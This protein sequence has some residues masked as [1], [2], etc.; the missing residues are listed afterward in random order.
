MNDRVT[1]T[2]VD[3]PDTQVDDDAPKAEATQV[4]PDARDA[5]LRKPPNRKHRRGRRVLLSA[6]G[7]VVGL[8]VS[9]EIFRLRDAGAF[10]HLNVYEPD[11][12]LG[13]RLRPFA[14]EKV[15][16]NGNPVTDVR[17]GA[18][19][20]RGP[21]LPPR[22]DDEII[23]VGDSQ[24]FGLG[25]Q[26]DETFSAVLSK[27]ANGRVVINAGVP[28]YGPDEY[29]AVAKRL[30]ESRHPDKSTARGLTVVYVVNLANDLFEA[31]RRN[32]DRHEVW[33]GWAV[34]KE[35]APQS[36]TRFPGRTFL[37]RDSHLF[38]ALRGVGVSRST[39]S[40]FGSE[41]SWKDLAVVARDVS[42]GESTAEA[43]FVAEQ[44]KEEEGLQASQLEVEKALLAKHPDLVADKAGKAYAKAHGSPEDIVVEETYFVPSEASRGHE[45]TVH[46][47]VAGAEVRR[48]VEAR[49]RREV[50]AESKAGAPDTSLAASFQERLQKQRKLD[51]LLAAP[52]HNARASSPMAPHL[53]KMKEL[54]D[55]HGARLV[56]VALPLDVQVSPAEWAKYGVSA[57][58]I[59]V[60]STGILADD[61][62][63]LSRDLGVS[64]LDP[65]SALAQAEPGA[66]LRGDLHMTAKGH[67]AL[68]NALL[69]TLREPPPTQEEPLALPAGRTRAPTEE[70]WQKGLHVA[71]RSPPLFDKTYYQP[72]LDCA[73]HTV[74]EW[75]RFVCKKDPAV[76]DPYH[77]G[78][79]GPRP[80]SLSAVRA[81]R[82]TMTLTTDTY[83]S[84]TVPMDGPPAIL[85]IA[86]ETGNG[87]ITIQ[88]SGDAI[89]LGWARKDRLAVWDF[90]QPAASAQAKKAEVTVTP[91]ATDMCACHEAVTKSAA[92]EAF[93]GAPDADCVRTYGSDCKKLL[94][95]EAGD[96]FMAP[97]CLPGWRHAGALE[98]CFQTCGAA[99]PCK[100]GACTQTQGVSLCL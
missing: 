37:Y 35:T 85:A 79:P 24:V 12:E 94:R 50:E 4:D 3:G 2:F 20:Y 42:A 6:L 75:V 93:P 89:E 15:S 81:S 54:C 63:A 31:A 8:G 58:P 23:I 5:S 72:P 56:V 65:K 87:E 18:E 80:V 90:D 40:G 26:E 30:L 14:T 78:S 34:R 83:A 74:R 92:C 33:D 13:T 52:L 68:A 48:L 1:L 45:V 16:F 38:F 84:A 86:W 10:P 57:P 19:G 77:A 97:K 22:A 100:V 62:V 25:V 39:S 9:E 71:F 21:G 59:D 46:S 47:L 66:F 64:A 96:P 51:A 53:T 44:K 76:A 69:V 60:A 67:A 32:V 55:A 82:D 7:L 28:T 36:V 61:I 11:A 27:A 95:C 41:G 49:I 99:S 73:I 91:G 70:E 88:R 43:S 29:A 98:H 17:I